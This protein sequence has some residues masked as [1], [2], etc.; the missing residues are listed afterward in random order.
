MTQRIEVGDERLLEW[1]RGWVAVARELGALLG[2]P[3]EEGI[4]E[5]AALERMWEV[6]LAN[7]LDGVES[8]RVITPIG[9]AFGDHLVQRW[10][11]T[12]V[13]ATDEWGTD[14]AVH[15][16]PGDVLLFPVDFVSKRDESRAPIPLVEASD[17]LGEVL[18]KARAE[19]RAH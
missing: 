11:L 4:P 14:V 17:R 15:G 6:W 18:A 3:I 12:W 2:T 9:C 1:V 8:D 7:G 13:V 5:P 10:D 16:S 19:W